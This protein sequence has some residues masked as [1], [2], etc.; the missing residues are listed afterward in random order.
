MTTEIRILDS[1]SIKRIETP[2]LFLSGDRREYFRMGAQMR[3]H[4]STLHGIEN[5]VG[6]VG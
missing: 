3:T 4:L 2:P 5:K 6:Y 1:D